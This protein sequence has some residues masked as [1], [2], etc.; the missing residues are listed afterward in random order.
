M[1]LFDSSTVL[2][3]EMRGY[4][5]RERDGEIHATNVLGQT[6]NTSKL[7]SPG[8][9]RFL[10]SSVCLSWLSLLG[11]CVFVFLIYVVSVVSMW[12]QTCSK[13]RKKSY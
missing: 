12:V 8:R 10:L 7:K 2:S 1:P 13:N 4:E 11:L 6:V 5:R 3:I 9:Q